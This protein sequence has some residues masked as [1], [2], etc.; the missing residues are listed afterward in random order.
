MEPISTKKLIIGS[1]WIHQIKWDGIRGL[2]YIDGDNLRVYTKNGNERTAYY[3]E[4]SDARKLVKAN[5]AVLDGEIII[6]SDDGRPSFHRSLIRERVTSTGKVKYYMAKYPALYAIFDI[7]YLEDKPV[8]SLPLHDRREI[9][10]S[11]VE[12]G[13]SIMITDD[14]TDGQGLFELMKQKSWEGIVTKNINSPYLP[15]KEHSAWYKLK[16]IK[17]LLAVVCGASLK[18]SLPNSLILGVNR[19]DGLSF[20]GK[21]SLGLTQ[22]DLYLIKE[23]IPKLKSNASPFQEPPR[24]KEPDVVW[25]APVLTCWVSFLEWTNDGVLRHPKILGFAS[26]SPKDADGREWA[27]DERA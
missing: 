5:R 18:A 13:Q 3:P 14:F 8:T 15:A 26:S 9:L 6:L 2:T 1:D 27:L 7:L 17:K 4:L 12:Q 11:I 16:T 24:L 22:N 21:A 19:E 23:H 20:I 10:L 25:F